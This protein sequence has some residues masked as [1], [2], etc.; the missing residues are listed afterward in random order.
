MIK[1]F[2]LSDIHAQFSLLTEALNKASFDIKNKD[3]ILIISGDILDRGKQGDLVIRFIESLILD[4]RVLAVLGNHDVFLK[5]ILENNIDVEKIEFNIVHNGSGETLKLIKYIN[6]NELTNTSIIKFGQKFIETYPIFSNW[7]TSIPLFLEFKN[8]VIVHA[9]LD[10]NLTDWRNTSI[11]YTTWSR[12]YKN[13]IPISFGKKL[14]FGHTPNVLINGKDDIIFDGY[15][16][17]IDGGAAM[18]HQINILILTEN[19]I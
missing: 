5:E 19:T 2:I 1:Y 16:I 8:H 11:R 4:K 12:D 10:F 17:M 15:K 13:K 18:N 14:I 9:F 7:L 6:L 3:H